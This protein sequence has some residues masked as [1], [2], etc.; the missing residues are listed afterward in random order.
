[1]C[2][3]PG[4]VSLICPLLLANTE[5]V[6]YG[7]LRAIVAPSEHNSLIGLYCQQNFDPLSLSS[8]PDI[9][10][11]PEVCFKRAVIKRR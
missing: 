2:R 3:E 4:H 9:E 7:V 1:V 6:H 10:I 11:C 5:N 8:I